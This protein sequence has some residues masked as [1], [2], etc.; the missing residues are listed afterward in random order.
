MYLN[1]TEQQL[2]KIAKRENNMKRSYL[3]VNPLQGKHVPV[4]PGEALALSGAL[5]ELLKGKIEVSRTLLIGFAE[6]ATA[7]GANAAVT[8]GTKYMQTT[9]EIIPGVS[10]LF[11]SEAHSHATEQKLVADDL[12]AVISEID[13]IVFVEDEVTT[14]N[15]ILQIIE[16]LRKRYPGKLEFSVASLLNGMTEEH[17]KRY[18]NENIGLYFLVKTDHSRYGDAADRYVADGTYVDCVCDGADQECEGAESEAASPEIVSE[19]AESA[20]NYCELRIP[21]AVDSRRLVDAPAYKAACDKLYEQ[22]MS[23][24]GEITGKRILVIGTEECM[25]PAIFVGQ[26]MEAAGNLVRTHSTTRSPI[27]VSRDPA[28]PLHS[29]YELRSLYGDGRVTFLYEIASYD[30][31]FV[32]TDAAEGAE[33]GTKSLI[34][35]LGRQNTDITL[36]RWCK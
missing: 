2:A 5:A 28:Y 27:L 17:L 13:L 31:V 11:F 20:I 6:T 32:I 1:Y 19:N 34:R 30:K 18:E 29:R 24:Q 15:T 26:K 16:I 23:G 33:K 4:S 35:A 25:Y 8:L 21:G 9:R 7:I 22:I 3:V 10:Y 14:G 12:D 36:V